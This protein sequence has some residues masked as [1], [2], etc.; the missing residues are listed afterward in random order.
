MKRAIIRLTPE[1]I[2]KLLGVPDH[3]LVLMAETGRQISDPCVYL[4]V[5]GDD[6]LFKAFEGWELT[7]I[8]ESDIYALQPKDEPPPEGEDSGTAEDS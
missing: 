2:G 4:H 1:F 8:P 6:R 3:V 7:H 5:A